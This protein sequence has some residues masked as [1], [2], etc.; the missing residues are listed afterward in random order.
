MRYF[1]VARF[2]V[3][4]PE[5]NSW[6]LPPGQLQTAGQEQSTIPSLPPT[7]Q[8]H[9]FRTNDVLL[10]LRPQVHT[11]ISASCTT[12]LKPKKGYFVLVFSHRLGTYLAETVTLQNPDAFPTM[13]A[14]RGAGGSAED[15][16]KNPI[17]SNSNKTLD[18][19]H[20]SNYNA[21]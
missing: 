5:G 11:I 13:K 15:I 20:H 2:Q 19:Q 7:R 14:M 17:Q 9:H 3:F 18:A 12:W 10:S 1:K 6:S 16:S 8:D 4:V 21:P